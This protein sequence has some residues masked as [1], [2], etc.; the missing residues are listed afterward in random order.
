MGPPAQVQG[1]IFNSIRV[2]VDIE[3]PKMRMQLRLNQFRA[4]K[5]AAVSS[6]IFNTQIR[7]A[8]V[9]RRSVAL[10]L[11]VILVGTEVA[12]GADSVTN[13]YRILATE[14]LQHEPATP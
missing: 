1:I 5:R 7:D 14:I 2:G 12:D 11:P 3:V 13:D 8:M 9:V 4:A 10:G 6:K